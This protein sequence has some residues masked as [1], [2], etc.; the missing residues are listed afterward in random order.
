[1]CV[2]A[3]A[4][5]LRAMFIDQKYTTV[6]VGGNPWARWIRT[7]RSRDDDGRPAADS[8]SCSCRRETRSWPSSGAP[9]IGRHGSA[10]LFY[11]QN[12][13]KRKRTM[14]N[15]SLTLLNGQQWFKNGFT[16]TPERPSPSSSSSLAVRRSPPLAASAE[17]KVR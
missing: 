2:G 15:E 6:L 4:Q 12:K 10:F 17:I 14:T 11:G 3:P 8:C 1:M 13:R 16:K 5:Q 9:V 7:L